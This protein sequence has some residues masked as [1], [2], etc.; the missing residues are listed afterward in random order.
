MAFDNPDHEV[1]EAVKEYRVALRNLT[2]AA[3]QF[4]P[5]EAE[6]ISHTTAF[7]DSIGF[8]YEKKTPALKSAIT[9]AK[10][11]LGE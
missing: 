8:D 5:F 4:L 3:E 10:K 7:L 9:E 1:E 11:V 6:I 2:A